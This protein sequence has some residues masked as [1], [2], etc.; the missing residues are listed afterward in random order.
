MNDSYIVLSDP[1]L[2]FDDVMCVC[3]VLP[4]PKKNATLTLSLTKLSKV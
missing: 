2:L 3:C 1:A 4:C